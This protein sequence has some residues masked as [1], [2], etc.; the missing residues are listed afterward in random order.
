MYVAV[1]S[2]PVAGASRSADGVVALQV[3]AFNSSGGNVIV[4]TPGRLEDILRR[5]P[6]LPVLCKVGLRL[7][8]AFWHTAHC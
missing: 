3:A 1:L 6:S 4:A 2:T 8:R 7:Q 5:V